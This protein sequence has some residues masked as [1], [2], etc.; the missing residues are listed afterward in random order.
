VLE[1]GNVPIAGFYWR[2]IR[3]L[4]DVHWTVRD[5]DSLFFVAVDNLQGAVMGL[6]KT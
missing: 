2:L 4:G 3:K 6:S 5:E 1:I